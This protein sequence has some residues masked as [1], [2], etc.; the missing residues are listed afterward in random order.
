M[1]R[2][3]LVLVLVGGAAI[4]LPCRSRAQDLAGLVADA[5]SG[6]PIVGAELRFLQGGPVA[7]TTGSGAFRL[8][9]HG[10]QDTVAIRA[11]GYLPVRVVVGVRTAPLL[12]RLQ[13]AATTL[14]DLVAIAGLRTQAAAGIVMPVQRVEREELLAT[15]ALSVVEVLRTQPGLQATTSPPTG[16][17]IAIRGIGD[18]RVLVLRDGEPAPGQMLEDRDLSRLSTVGVDHIEVVKGPLSV[19]HGSQALGGVINIVSQVPKGALHADAATHGGSLGRRDATLTVQQGGRVAWR[20]T[21]GGR[22]QDRIPGQVEQQGTRQRLVD[23]QASVRTTVGPVALRFDASAFR[24][25]QRWGVG[26][27]F[28]AFNDNTGVT[29]W[30]EA[31]LDALGGS[32]RLRLSNQEFRHRFRQALGD[33]P[34]ADTGA[35]TQ[36]EQTR[37]LQ[38]SHSRRVGGRHQVDLG[39][40]ASR[41]RVVAADRLLGERLSDAMLEGYAQDAITAGPLLVT[42][43]ARYTHNSR[44]GNALTPSVGVAL[45]PSGTLRLRMGAARGFRGP[46]FKELG[47]RFL[48][49]AAGYTVEGNDA[50]VPESS[51]QVFTGATWAP[52]PALRVDADLYRNELREMI[53]L[54]LVGSTDA[55][56]LRYTPQNRAR[57]RT[58]GLE[59]A[60]SYQRAPLHLSASYERLQATDRTTGLPLSQR[61]P[62]TVRLHADRRLRALR[63]DVTG[64][65]VAKAPVLD[66]AG[67]RLADQGALLTWDASA[68]LA[69]GHRL[70]LEAGVDNLFDARPAGWQIALQRTVRL[71]LRVGATP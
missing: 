55:G 45:E 25:R 37:R 69:Q 5:Q 43:A 54:V 50:L 14:A 24:E 11:I 16:S 32:W 70:T 18:G 61:A 34:Y 19:I 49:V 23:G 56:L 40:D 51:W 21:V 57:A 44:W 12:V 63:L 20:A 48:N 41:R 60:V 38:V 3:V 67:T 22:Q 52:S 47:W 64:R 13:S 42:M 26:G 58:Q 68:Q 46:S 2:A 59:L 65:W 33:V 62:H 1:R 36:E 29:A 30:S 4:A 66:A 27:G 8:P 10:P 31:S 17:G 6:A 15:G 28:F 71:G 7:I 39:I 53:D 35:P 9:R